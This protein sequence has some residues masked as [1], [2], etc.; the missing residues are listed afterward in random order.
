[1][2]LAC[3]DGGLS[4]S[5]AL[6]QKGLNDEDAR[7]CRE[8]NGRRMG[9]AKNVR[10]ARHSVL[11]GADKGRVMSN[12]GWGGLCSESDAKVSIDWA[13]YSIPASLVRFCNTRE[14]KETSLTPSDA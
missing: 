10:T 6:R 4:V 11:E 3:W 14:Y 9:R 5:V 7:G 12:V 13:A 1:M 2:R 8:A